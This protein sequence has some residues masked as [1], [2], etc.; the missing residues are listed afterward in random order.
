MSS[1]VSNQNGSYIVLVFPA[2]SSPECPSFPLHISSSLSSRINLGGNVEQFCS[3]CDHQAECDGECPCLPAAVLSHRPRSYGV[4]C[5]SLS[6]QL[7]SST[8]IVSAATLHHLSEDLS[9]LA[10]QVVAAAV[11]VIT[12]AASSLTGLILTSFSIVGL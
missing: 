6:D 7:P 1:F 5:L 8:L 12:T 10:K 11:L 2:F 3:R 9:D 4:P